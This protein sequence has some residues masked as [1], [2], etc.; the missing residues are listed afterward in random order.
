MRRILLLTLALSIAA[1]GAVPTADAATAKRCQAA[2]K[3]AK[4]KVIKKGKSS[5]V[6]RR[7]RET[8]IGARYY[9]CLYSKPKLYK[10]SNRYAGDTDFYDGFKLNGRYLA[11]VHQNV[12][13]AA[14][15]FPAY[16]EL[17]DLRA[18]R[19]V[20]KFDGFPGADTFSVTQFILQPNGA[21]AWIGE[22]GR[23][24]PT[25]RSVQ[26]ALVGQDTPVEVERGTAIGQTSLRR[27]PGDP[28]RFSWLSGGARK[29]AAFGG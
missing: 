13:E 3:K 24:E 25:Q 14:S 19:Q 26:T 28:T 20:H 29:S 7:G 4:A 21:I 15:D 18:R 17:V 16:I 6:A 11:Y 27:V 2:A 12:E 1:F 10:F 9:G 5:L 23:S 22:D 8:E